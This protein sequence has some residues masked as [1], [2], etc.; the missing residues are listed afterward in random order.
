MTGSLICKLESVKRAL[1]ENSCLKFPPGKV[2]QVAECDRILCMQGKDGIDQC[3]YVHPQ[4]LDIFDLH[5]FVV[6]N[7]GNCPKIT[8]CDHTGSHMVT[9][10]C[11][12]L[13]RTFPR[14]NAV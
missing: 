12:K 11:Q 3:K 6:F 10:D 14:I 5:H 7:L 13:H 4:W 2:W 9:R 8:K 1:T